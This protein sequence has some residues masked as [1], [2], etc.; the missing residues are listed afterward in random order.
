MLGVKHI[1]KDSNGNVLTKNWSC[2][3]SDATG[4]NLA[5]CV[6]GEYIYTS[7][8]SGATW[9]QTEALSNKNWT[10][11]TSDATGQYLAAT[12]YNK[13]GIYLNS[14]YGN[15]EWK[16]AVIPSDYANNYSTC[17]RSSSDG[18]KLVAAISSADTYY[19]LYANDE[20]GNGEW[21]NTGVDQFKIYWCATNFAD[22]PAYRD[23]TA[24]LQAYVAVKRG[25]KDQF[26]PGISDGS[27]S[28]VIFGNEN[29]YYASNIKINGPNRRGIYKIEL[30]D[31][32]YEIILTN[33]K[34]IDNVS[35]LTIS[36]DGKKLAG[37]C[38]TY[39]NGGSYINN[40]G[41]IYTSTDSGVNWTE[42][43]S[44]GIK[45]W[46]SIASS[47][48]SNQFVACTYG[49][50]IYT[51]AYNVTNVTFESGS[52]IVNLISDDTIVEKFTT[53]P[54]LLITKIL[55]DG[56]YS[57]QSI[58]NIFERLKFFVF[59]DSTIDITKYN[60]AA[61]LSAEAYAQAYTEIVYALTDKY[62]NGEITIEQ[63]NI[64]LE[65]SAE[66]LAENYPRWY[67]NNLIKIEAAIIKYRY[68][69]E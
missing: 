58:R 61:F 3:A 4:T 8:D 51:L 20:Y 44:L 25:T 57:D 9:T 35:S 47:S 33:L 68:I 15:G 2:V 42:Q 52:E 37:C 28:S 56:D 39:Y 66:Q 17:I 64:A 54:G 38:G 14:N 69:L 60:L 5:A 26:I 23:Y 67:F 18:K 62:N 63:Y 43:T 7:S 29:V 53:I 40:S 11:I 36:N 59:S 6:Y 55:E 32:K 1:G 24:A 41:Y 22:D 48:D 13:N 19:R 50:N 34:E 21:Y 46:S 27:W 45:Y 30:T 65:D 12:S 16:Q 49:G 31:T 10:S